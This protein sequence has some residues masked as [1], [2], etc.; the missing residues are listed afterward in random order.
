[1]TNNPALNKTPPTISVNQC[2]QEIILPITIKAEKA[3]DA[4]SIILFSV[5]FDNL[6]LTCSTNVGITDS[7]SNVVEDG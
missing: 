6:R 7:T 3:I 2:T 5:T 4:T 1:M